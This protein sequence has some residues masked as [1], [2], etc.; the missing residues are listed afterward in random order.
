VA[1]VIQRNTVEL[2]PMSAPRVWPERIADFGGPSA[3][4]SA[5]TS[6]RANRRVETR[7]RASQLGDALGGA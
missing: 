2:N 1:A 4:H 7:R 6:P 3:A 5:K